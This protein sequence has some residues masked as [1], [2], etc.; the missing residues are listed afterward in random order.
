MGGE[1]LP[2]RWQ[3]VCTCYCKTSDVACN[4]SKH[5]ACSLCVDRNASMRAWAKHADLKH[6]ASCMGALDPLMI[7]VALRLSMLQASDLWPASFVITLAGMQRCSKCHCLVHQ[8]A[9][10]GDNAAGLVCCE[11]EAW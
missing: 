6:L 1:E 4:F 10:F 8:P 11:L 3:L 2:W 7:R 9:V 5:H